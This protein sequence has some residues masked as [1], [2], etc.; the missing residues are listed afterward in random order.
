M[1][2]RQ[3]EEAQQS[4]WFRN[5]VNKVAGISVRR[6]SPRYSR[7]KECRFHSWKHVPGAAHSQK[8][9]ITRGRGTRAGPGTCPYHSRSSLLMLQKMLSWVVRAGSRWL[10]SVPGAPSLLQP[11]A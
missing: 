8:D 7:L 1:T 2:G 9:G 6:D 3:R 10:L 11:K 5:L 4:G